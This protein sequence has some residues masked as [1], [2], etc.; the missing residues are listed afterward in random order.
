VSL[1][2]LWAELRTELHCLQTLELG[3]DLHRSLLSNGV[4]AE[5]LE[6]WVL[7]ER[8]RKAPKCAKG[9]TLDPE[10]IVQELVD[11][12]ASVAGGAALRA[13]LGMNGS[14]DVD[15]FVR[16]LSSFAS[17][18][19]IAWSYPTV[20]VC[21]YRNEPWELFDLAAGMCAWSSSGFSCDPRHEESIKTKVSDIELGAIVHPR[22]TLGRIV[23]YGQQY[24]FRFPASKVM[25]MA[26]GCPDGS[27]AMKF[28]ALE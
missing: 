27:E 24:G 6:E 23:K 7:S 8:T 3:S 15:I 28:A 10:E 17:A 11:R 2:H 18:L 21:L 16:G 12:G 5:A 22:A 1:R 26:I 20:D 4:D 13:R 19:L 9:Q 14:R 25:M